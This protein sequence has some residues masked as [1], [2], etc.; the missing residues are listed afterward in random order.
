MRQ[1]SQ[2]ADASPLVSLV[3]L[4]SLETPQETLLCLWN[5]SVSGMS[6]SQECLCV[7]GVRV[8]RGV[9]TEHG[10]TLRNTALVSVVY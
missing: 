2:P 4:V 6:L 3:S 10:G 9:S 7:S 8:S 1:K 5:V